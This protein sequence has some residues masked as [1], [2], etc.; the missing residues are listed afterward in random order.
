MTTLLPRGYGG[1]PSFQFSP[2]NQINTRYY[3]G[4]QPRR[5]ASF[6]PHYPTQPLYQPPFNPIEGYPAPFV[7]QVREP[8]L[9]TQLVLL[10]N[11]LDE[12]Y[13]YETYLRQLEKMQKRYWK[14]QANTMPLPMYSAPPP[15]LNYASNAVYEYE[16]ETKY[17]P[18]PVFVN[19]G[20]GRN[21]G[22]P[23]GST[24][25]FGTGGGMNLPPKIRVIFI[26]TGQ[27]F[28]QQPSTGSLVSNSF[29]H[30]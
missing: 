19:P 10:F 12:Q 16:K 26:P 18:Y 7:N 22:Y 9:G 4:R 28:S 5:G 29:Y 13:R 21:L 11:Q 20:A 3:N 8:G 14:Q 1:F 30:P 25:P 6:A 23:Y 24:V 2:P 17:I 15:P 27:S